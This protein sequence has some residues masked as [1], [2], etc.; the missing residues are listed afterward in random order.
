MNDSIVR[1][2]AEIIQNTMINIAAYTSELRQSYSKLYDEL[3]SA[4][5][6]RD[7]QFEQFM[8]AFARAL[9]DLQSARVTALASIAKE[10]RSFSASGAQSEVGRA[11]PCAP[12]APVV[13]RQ[14]RAS[15]P[16]APGGRASREPR[17]PAMVDIAG[18]TYYAP[19]LAKSL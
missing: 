9:N 1:I 5:P 7:R 17:Q 13:V 6:Q 11:V 14:S 12:S 15:A 2:H 19:E 10:M 18:E 16:S 4:D 8:L 3:D